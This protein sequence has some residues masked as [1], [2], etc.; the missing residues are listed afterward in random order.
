[1]IL[2]WSRKAITVRAHEGIVGRWKSQWTTDF[3]QNSRTYIVYNSHVTYSNS[4]FSLTMVMH[5]S[6]FP[7]VML[8]VPHFCGWTHLSPSLNSTTSIGEGDILII[9]LLILSSARCSCLNIRWYTAPVGMVT[10]CQ[11]PCW[12]YPQLDA[13]VSTSA[14]DIPVI[15]PI[16]SMYPSTTSTVF[17]PAGH[18]NILL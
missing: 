16:L 1:M 17:T 18:I 2:V 14:H 11:S 7:L 8:F 4:S 13:T 3:S 10:F 12:Y 9:T 15:T 5:T 6:C